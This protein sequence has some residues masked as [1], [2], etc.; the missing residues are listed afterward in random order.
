MPCI[1]N[2]CR[3]LCNVSNESF[4]NRK[5]QIGDKTKDSNTFWKRRLLRIKFHV[6]N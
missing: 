6:Q 3:G 1:G 5:Q 4:P 2:Q